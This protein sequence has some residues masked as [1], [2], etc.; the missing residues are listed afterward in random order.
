MPKRE[1]M[2]SVD[3]AWLRMDTDENLMMIVGVM[4]LLAGMAEIVAAFGV[5]SWS[6]FVM[7]LLLGALYVFAGFICLQNP[8]AAA[9][10]LT[11]MLGVA[12]IASGLND[13]MINWFAEPGPAFAAVCIT[14][15]WKGYPFVSI[16]V[17]AG[18]QSI[19][20]DL[21]HAARVDGKTAVLRAPSPDGVVV[22]EPEP[23]RVHPRVA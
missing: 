8:F 12:L 9:T 4:M 13:K 1:R 19:P 3:T 21:F 18:L 2:S 15:I 22:F 17:L 7:W 10:L 11:L 6:R 20:E 5:R 16:M 14:M 23:E